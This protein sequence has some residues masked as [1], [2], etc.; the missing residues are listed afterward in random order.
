MLC[1]PVNGHEPGAEEVGQADEHQRLDAVPK[2]RKTEDHKIN[3]KSYSGL[4]IY[5]RKFDCRN[6]GR[7]GRIHAPDCVHYQV[8]EIVSVNRNIEKA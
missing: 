3:R 8:S 7:F 5:G 2:R 4:A 1:Q 6:V